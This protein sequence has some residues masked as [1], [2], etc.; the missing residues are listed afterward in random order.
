[1]DLS[2]IKKMAE[3]L[4]KNLLTLKLKVNEIEDS[5][6]NKDAKAQVLAQIKNFENTVK[7]VSS[8]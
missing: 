7:D 8:T 3:E 6:E 2:E 4:S 5:E 1:M